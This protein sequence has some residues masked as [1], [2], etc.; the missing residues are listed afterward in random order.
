MGVKVLALVPIVCAALAAP[1]SAAPFRM[2]PAHALLIEAD[3]QDPA[4]LPPRFRNHCSIDPLSGR[5][6]CS[7][8]CGVDYQIYSCSR[9][10]FGCCRLGHGY[11]DG[12][13]Q[14]RCAP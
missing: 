14:L 13:G 7:N 11:C 3:W 2:P 1:G 9:F 4:L 5:P 10:S 6:Y 8:H 12:N